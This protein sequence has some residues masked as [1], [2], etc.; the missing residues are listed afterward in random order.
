MGGVG[1]QNQTTSN[2]G[3]GDKINLSVVA[4][5]HYITINEIFLLKYL[6]YMP[7]LSN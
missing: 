6:L 7:Y 5:Q 2:E 4:K 3:G 1:E